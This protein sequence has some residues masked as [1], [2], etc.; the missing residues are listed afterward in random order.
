MSSQIMRAGLHVASRDETESH[1]HA[2]HF[3]PSER[4]QPA[5]FLLH[6]IADTQ[7]YISP[8]SAWYVSARY[9]P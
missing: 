8:G 1:M 5:S 6:C 4:C 9:D 3:V 7:Q 2:H